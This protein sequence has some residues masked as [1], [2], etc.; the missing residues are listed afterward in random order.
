MEPFA[1]EIGNA[2][3]MRSKKGRVKPH[4]FS[5]VTPHRRIQSRFL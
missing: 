4:S 3:E 5:K 1:A 2:H